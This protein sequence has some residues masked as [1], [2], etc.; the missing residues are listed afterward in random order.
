[1]WCKSM[2]EELKASMTQRIRIVVTSLLL[3]LLFVPCAVAS[4]ADQLELTPFEAINYYAVR[5]GGRID[6]YA[7]AVT[8]FLNPE[9]EL[10][11]KV[12]MAVPAGTELIWAGEFS[13]V[14]GPVEP[15]FEEP[16]D[17]RSENGLDIYTV[18]LENYPALQFE[19]SLPEQLHDYISDDLHV[20]NL[21]YTPAENLPILRLMARLPA[22]SVVTDSAAEFMGMDADE[23]LVYMHIFHNV[24]AFQPVQANISYIPPEDMTLPFETSVGGGIIIAIVAVG[25]TAILAAGF[26]FVA[27]K[28]RR[29]AEQEQGEVS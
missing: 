19:Y 8:G 20:I 3:L 26:I 27:R 1:M 18:I 16:F 9:V 24:P 25:I 5:M 2:T 14:L 23:N 28:N 29:R 15:A 11:A 21:S 12:E 22:E 10:P 17:V 13:E 4:S 7:I 6:A